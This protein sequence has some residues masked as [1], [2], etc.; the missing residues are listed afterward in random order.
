MSHYLQGFDP[1]TLS[2]CMLIHREAP[3]MSPSDVHPPDAT[4]PFKALSRPRRMQSCSSF[5]T[6]MS[7]GGGTCGLGEITPPGCWSVSNHFHP[8][9]RFQRAQTRTDPQCC[10]RR[11]STLRFTDTPS[12]LKKHAGPYSPLSRKKSSIP[13]SLRATLCHRT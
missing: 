12:S 3:L 8:W 1:N 9:V 11:P 13:D 6:S 2:K 5:A 7:R 10:L 4:P